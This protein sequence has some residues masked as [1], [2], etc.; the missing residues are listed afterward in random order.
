MLEMTTCE[1]AEVL[2]FQQAWLTEPESG[3]QSG[4]V[5]VGWRPDGFRMHAKLQ[6]RD[7][8]NPEREFNRRFF[9]QGDTL[10]WFVQPPESEAY[11]EFHIGPDAQLYQVRF[12]SRP[13]FDQI[14]ATGIPSDWMMTEP[15]IDATCRI[16]GGFWTLEAFLPISM[17]E[18]GHI[19]AK[20]VWRMSF[21]RYDYNREP[22]SL[23]LSSTSSIR[24]PDF[25]RIEEWSKFLIK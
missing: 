24:R 9:L 17:L 6:D 11:W 25:H 20:E 5:K 1:D 2:V 10:E 21:C 8:F 7:V 18:R 13:A 12:P 22:D 14:R 23:I 3:F 15:V 19:Q 4:E 16:E